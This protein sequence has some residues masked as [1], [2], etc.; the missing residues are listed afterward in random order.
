MKN[1]FFSLYY[2]TLAAGLLVSAF[3][4]GTSTDL[5]GAHGILLI[6][7]AIAWYWLP[8]MVAFHRD[9]RNAISV[10]LVNLLTGWTGIGWLIALVMALLGR[11]H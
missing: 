10:G 4:K 7:Y 5:S 3:S 6:A 1:L 11:R 8:L 2:L 9:T